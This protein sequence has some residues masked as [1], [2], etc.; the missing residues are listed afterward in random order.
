M[1]TIIKTTLL[2]FLMYQS[3]AQDYIHNIH[4]ET[5]SLSRPKI[6]LH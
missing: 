1:K 2:S 6:G 3:F 4:C 5:D